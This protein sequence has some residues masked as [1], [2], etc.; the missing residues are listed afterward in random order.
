MHAFSTA[1]PH[2]S[3]T[4]YYATHAIVICV[5]LAVF[6]IIRHN[7]AA[8]V[9]LVFGSSVI[10]AV[11]STGINSLLTNQIC[12]KYLQTEKKLSTYEK[13]SV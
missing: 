13:N 1:Q 3:I 12:Q 6:D 10:V 7:K 2:V 11:I 9:Q 5:L 4:V 8:A